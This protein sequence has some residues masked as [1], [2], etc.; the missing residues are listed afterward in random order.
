MLFFCCFLLF[1]FFLISSE[2]F[3]SQILN[4][5]VKCLHG[6]I[7]YKVSRKIRVSG[8]RCKFALGGANIDEDASSRCRL[9]KINILRLYDFQNSGD[10]EKRETLLESDKK[11]WSLLRLT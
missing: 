7:A 10:K 2:P 3:C 5:M 8:N 1:L 6:A 9:E 11:K 4:N